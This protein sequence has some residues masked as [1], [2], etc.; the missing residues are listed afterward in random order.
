MLQ[1][2]LAMFTKDELMTLYN[3]LEKFQREMSRST[4]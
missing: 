2:A 4:G 1:K 3:L